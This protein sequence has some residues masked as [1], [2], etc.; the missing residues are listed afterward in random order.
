MASKLENE[1]LGRIQASRTYVQ[2]W[3][4]NVRKW[5]KLYNTHEDDEKARRNEVRYNDP[6]YANTV[7]LAVGIMLGNHLR[8][9]AF[10]FS[11]SQKEQENSSKIEKLIA[12][13]I[14]INN[15]REQK[16]ILYEA[17][18]NF[19]RDGGAVLYSPVDPAL[20]KELSVTAEFPDPSSET[21]LKKMKALSEPPVRLKTI[22]PLKFFA[23]PGGPKRWIMMAREESMSVLD[24][25]LKYGVSIEW[26]RGSSE[27]E[28]ST[29]KGKFLD[30][31]DYTKVKGELKVRNTQVFDGK[32]IKGPRIMK[33]Y[34]ELPFSFE[35]FKPTG[36]KSKDWH[37][38]ITPLESTLGLLET[39]V[40]RR[41]HQIDIYT[42]LPLI[43][44]T[45]PGRTVKVDTGL[46]SHVPLS[47]EE[48]IEFPSWPGNAPDVREH[49]DFLRTRV[50]QSGFSDVMFGSGQNSVSGF[51]LNQLG[52]QNRIRL[53]QPI[54]HL[55]LLLSLWAKKTLRLLE[56]F[57][58]DTPICVYGQ[59]KGKSYQD[60]VTMKDLKGYAVIA[61]IR[62]KFP[63]EETRK[64]AMSTQVKGVLSQST[65]MERFLDVEQPDDEEERK[66]IESATNH[67]LMMQYAIIKKIKER[68][69]GG[70][71]VAAIAL[72]SIMNGG[73]PGFAGRPNEPNNP[74]QTTG[75]QTPTGDSVP[76][77][78]QNQEPGSAV[79][80][81]QENLANASPGM[82]GSV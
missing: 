12:G 10:G 5:R 78:N 45:Q 23:L 26:A 76:T 38:I 64:V 22:D 31:W 40:N 73:L 42:G 18:T 72:Q 32:I 67:P 59:Y 16:H 34:D 3:H 9:H 27:I 77:T 19:C 1:I 24:V 25:E 48:S 61:E 4:D 15:L 52:D 60:Y 20:E 21:G 65:I 7:D 53:E 41:A 81:A 39:S 70:D 11:P 50:Q 36:E 44:K 2:D 69:D 47:T 35:F 74:E 8:W 49:Q 66:L 62:P 51:A 28:K 46:F 30:V 17:Y 13:I 63:A 55:E 57:Y 29:M 82:D 14:F 68:A 56:Y 33:G 71:E 43:T 54:K 58:S 80:N 79:I 6:T 37:S 75:L